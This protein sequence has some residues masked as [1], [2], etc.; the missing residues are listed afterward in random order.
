MPSIHLKAFRP[1]N[2]RL[3]VPA[4]TAHWSLAA[5]VAWPA[6]LVPL[7]LVYLPADLQVRAGDGL[8]LINEYQKYAAELFA[9]SITLAAFL[10]SKIKTRNWR[11]PPGALL[12]PVFC[13][14]LA[15]GTSL[16]QVSDLWLG[17]LIGL[18]VYLL[19]AGFFLLVATRFWSLP[20]GVAILAAA[21]LAG[22]LNSVVGIAQGLDLWAP[23]LALPHIGAGGL[24]YFQNLAGEYLIILIPPAIA[25]LCM[26]LRTIYRISATGACVLLATHLVLTLA[27]G[28]WVGLIG[29][30]L[31]GAALAGG[32]LLTAGGM[33]PGKARCRLHRKPILIMLLLSGL[34]LGLVTGTLRTNSFLGDGLSRSPYVQEFL[35]INLENSTGR[36]AIWKDSLGMLEKHWL[37]GVG[38]GHYRVNLPAY[39]R[40]I[41]AIPYL[42]NWDVVTGE[43]IIPFRAHNDYLQIWLELGVIGILGLVWLF[44][45]ITLISMR[46]FRDALMSRDRVRAL[47]IWGCFSG[48]AAWAVSMLFEFPFRMPASLVLGWLCAGLAVSFSLTGRNRPQ[49]TLPVPYRALAVATSCLLIFASLWLAHRQF[50]SDIYLNRAFAAAVTQ[51]TAES[52]AWINK[53]QVLAPWQEPAGTTKARLELIMGMPEEASAT[54]RKIL[55]RNPHSLP[56]LWAEGLAAGALG[57]EAESRAAFQKIVTLYPFLPDIENYRRFGNPA[58]P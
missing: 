41:P 22:I 39:L 21:L 5:A 31:L 23:A 54:A 46:G 11:R 34:V 3:V 9:L 51:D 30:L 38:P 32:G 50:W 4:R 25:I 14:V 58:E 20:Q 56:G 53:A 7:F 24:L 40:E 10:F 17:I 37:K 15:L 52:Y 6:I 57:R 16:F 27:R 33:A 43:L 47:L 2:N 35:S 45:A 29:G 26:P 36:V 13:L 12:W 18:Q 28:A 1:G 55:Q 42:F 8:V 19:P 44:G 48:F 49:I